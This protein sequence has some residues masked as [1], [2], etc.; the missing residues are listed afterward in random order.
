MRT[1]TDNGVVGGRE[2]IRKGRSRPESPPWFAVKITPEN[3]PWAFQSDG[4]AYRVI[5]TLEAL[6]FPSGPL[7]IRSGPRTR[8]HEDSHPSPLHYRDRDRDRGF[9]CIASFV[10]SPL[11]SFVL[12]IVFTPFDV[13]MVRVRVR[14]T[15][16]ETETETEVLLAATSHQE[17]PGMACAFWTASSTVAV[18]GSKTRSF[19]SMDTYINERSQS[20]AWPQQGGPT[21]PL[22][23][24]RTSR[25]GQ[26]RLLHWLGSS[27]RKQQHRQCRKNASEFCKARCSM[28]RL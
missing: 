28:R 16:T 8:R 11:C 6:G 1:R 19:P 10:P 24:L 27:R 25:K 14:L 22:R 3:A 5:A 17:V 7:G 9:G 18:R 15:E 21:E 20:A 2:P 12:A 26:H 13:Q 23:A 4:K